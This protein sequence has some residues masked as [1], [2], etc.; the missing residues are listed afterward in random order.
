MS[1]S[2]S[3]FITIIRNAYAARKDACLGKY[4]KMHL[5]IALIL[6]EEGYIRDVQEE[7]NN[8][9]KCLKV[10]LKYVDDTPAITGLKRHSSPGRRLYYG[11]DSIPRVLGGLGIA[12]LTTSKGVLKDRDARRDKVGGEMICSVW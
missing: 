12:I 8:G 3:D 2:I 4:S 7:T 5:R 9:H 6:K 11:S 10:T 1:D